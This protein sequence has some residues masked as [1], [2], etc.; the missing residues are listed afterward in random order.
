MRRVVFNR[1]GG[2]GK[3]SIVCN[4]AAAAAH[5]GIATLVVDLDPQANATSYL[6]GRDSARAEPTLLEFFEETLSFRLFDSEPYRFVHETPFAGL[7]ILTSSPGLSDLHSKLEARHKI[8]KLREALDHL[9][10][11]Q[12]VFIDTPRLSTSSPCRP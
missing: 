6:L 11:F 8:Y 2:V 3:T 5:S 1:K 10:S 9:E 4:L 7:S 12:W